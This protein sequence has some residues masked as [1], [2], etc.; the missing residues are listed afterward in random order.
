MV[1]EAAYAE[2]QANALLDEIKSIEEA[3]RSEGRKFDIRGDVGFM[4]KY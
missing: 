1:N 2:R 4:K 3:M